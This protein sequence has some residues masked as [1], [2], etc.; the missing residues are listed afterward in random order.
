[1]KSIISLLLVVL[2]AVGLI[3]SSGCAP[4]APAK[5]QPV[6]KTYVLMPTKESPTPRPEKPQVYGMPTKTLPDSVFKNVMV[7]PD[8]TPYKFAYLPHTLDCEWMAVVAGL[9]KSYAKRA[10]GEFILMD[11]KLSVE[12]QIADINDCIARGDIDAIIITAVDTSAV[13]PAIE[14]AADAGIPAFGIGD[15][16]VSDRFVSASWHDYMAIGEESAKQF[17]KIA[18]E[19]GKPL[20]VYEIWG[21]MGITSAQA[22]HVGLHKAEENPLIK[23]TEGPECSWSPALA[24]TAVMDVF[25]THP[26]WNAVYEMGSMS[27]GVIEG[28]RT[29]GRLYPSGDARHVYLVATDEPPDAV[30]GIRDGYVDACVGHSPYEEMDVC[31]KAAMKYVCLGKPVDRYYFCPM[32]AVTPE[33]MDSP[34]C[35]GN[36]SGKVPYDEWPILDI[37]ELIQFP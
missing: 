5:K 8:G 23:I 25:S 6:P 12:K 21:I 26:E 17:V 34:L 16:V 32:Y 24:A 10:G 36:L 20:T 29:I 3:V 19:T 31:M 18:T 22:R 4:T 30:Q 35:W 15:D 2:V 11:A 27:G 37:P 7:K 1:M 13:A 9:G 28:L 33:N 14:K